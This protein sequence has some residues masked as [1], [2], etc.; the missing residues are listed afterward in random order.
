MSIKKFLAIAIAI[1][2][3]VS[4]LS[5]SVFA[6]EADGSNE[7]PSNDIPTDEL[8]TTTSVP[9]LDDVPAND[10]LLADSSSKSF[11]DWVEANEGLVVTLGIIIVAALVFFVLWLVSPK[12]KAK[13]SKFWKDYNAEFKKLVWP[14]KEQL[15]RNS[16]VVI[17][18]I[19]VI[20]A[21]LA[22]LDLGFSKGMYA[23]KDL[24]QYI[25]PVA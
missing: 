9:D 10:V 19:I 12:F 18:S 14:T 16:A 6:D 24:I 21:V 2:M 5:V 7:I 23:L 22:L 25:M 3:M 13:N 11:G 17:V 15:W 4:V 8:L 1:V 20:G